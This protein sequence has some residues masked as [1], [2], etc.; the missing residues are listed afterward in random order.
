MAASC[1]VNNFLPMLT[2]FCEMQARNFT[3]TSLSHRN[4]NLKHLVT[5]FYRLNTALYILEF[6]F[7]SLWFGLDFIAHFPHFTIAHLRLTCSYPYPLS[8]SSLLLIPSF[9]LRAFHL[10][11]S[12][13]RLPPH[14][15]HTSPAAHASSLP[16]HA[17][18]R[19]HR[20]PLDGTGLCAACLPAPRFRAHRT[21][22][23]THPSTH[24]LRRA[25][26]TR[27]PHL[28]ARVRCCTCA[29]TTAHCTHCARA[30]ALRV[31]IEYNQ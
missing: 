16:A 30:R 13:A 27:A 10:A 21:H 23:R 19:A 8:T 20:T 6:S 9:S 1:L 14:I 28:F 18:P 11:S 22:V 7:G 5:C 29:C 3:S 26:R 24:L 2:L 17:P 31:N 12:A 25:P 15:C 4:T